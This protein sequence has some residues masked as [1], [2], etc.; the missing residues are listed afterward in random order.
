MEPMSLE[1]AVEQSALALPK[2]S[3]IMPIE[4]QEPRLSR[5]ELEQNM[6]WIPSR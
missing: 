4:D 5:D 1:A 2:P 6:G 3:V